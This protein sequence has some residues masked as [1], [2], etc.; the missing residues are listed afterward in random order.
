M[1][2]EFIAP[3]IDASIT[4]L[5]DILAVSVTKGRTS[6]KEAMAPTACLSVS[7]GLTGDVEGTV[8]FDIPEKTAF[9]IAGAMNCVRFDSIEPMVLDTL[10]EL[11]NMIVGRSVTLLN[12][13]G[14][15]FNLTPPT[16]FSGNNIKFYSTE[17]EALE[18]PVSTAHGD[19]VISVAMRTTV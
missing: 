7:F 13:R 15:M 6:L 11:M 17:I 5:N 10:A 14:F 9:E 12:E 8:L 2:F 19:F 16:I 3:F 4:V 1:R 18:V